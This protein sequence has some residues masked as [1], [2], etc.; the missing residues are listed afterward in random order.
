M[1]IDWFTVAAQALNLL[2][3]VWLLKRFLYKPVL[4]AIELR[5]KSVAAAV[6]DAEAKKSEALKE[7]DEFK[8]KN[9]EFDAQRAALLAKATADA[10]AEGLRLKGEAQKSADALAAK[11]KGSMLSDA[12]AL[13][14][15]VGL[16]VRQEVFAIAR[17]ALDDLAGTGLEERMVA[18]FLRR[19]QGLDAQAKGALGQ[20]LKAGPALL[21]SAVDLAPEQCAALQKGLNE[22]FSADI[23]LNFKTAPE[24][25]GGIEL[26]AHGQKLAWTIGDYLG[27]LEG[28]VGRLLETGGALGAPA[29]KDAPAPAAKP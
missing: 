23:H 2:I 3:L 13:D 16:K 17:K 14:Q 1:M 22:A 20:A 19:L 21:Q 26:L 4:N 25:G 27:S 10:A 7:R 24:L 12:R 28:D 8:R 15:A 11:Q 18:V 5:E 9:S 6:A 29:A